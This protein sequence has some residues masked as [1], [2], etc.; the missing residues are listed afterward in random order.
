MLSQDPPTTNSFQHSSSHTP[1]P[2]VNF[3]TCSN[4][5]PTH[6]ILLAAITKIVEPKFYH[7]ATQDPLWQK[8]MVGD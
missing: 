1:H 4:F 6:Q 3:V 5:S 2:I 8:A 7:E